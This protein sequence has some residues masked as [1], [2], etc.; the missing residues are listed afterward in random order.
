MNMFK[1]MEGQTSDYI[2][3]IVCMSFV[4][5]IVLL[6]LLTLLYFFAKVVLIIL[7]GIAFV[8][9]IGYGI[10]VLIYHIADQHDIKKNERE[11]KEKQER[12]ER[13]NRQV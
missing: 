1:E 12:K 7:F 2:S 10:L 3:M 4:F 13:L 6:G 11:E 8:W 5:G 9:G